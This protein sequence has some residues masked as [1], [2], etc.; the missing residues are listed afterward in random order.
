MRNMFQVVNEIRQ[1]RGNMKAFMLPDSI[2]WMQHQ[3][4]REKM[5]ELNVMI[6]KFLHYE[7][8]VLKV[9]ASKMDEM[10]EVLCV[11]GRNK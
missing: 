2:Q 11:L 3:Y 9:E 5:G 10:V 8:V 7:S 6:S 1:S 4:L